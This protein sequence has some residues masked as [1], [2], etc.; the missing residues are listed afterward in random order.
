MRLSTR[1]KEAVRRRYS[2]CRLARVGTS[3][4]LIARAERDDP[5]G[6]P[7][8]WYVFEVEDVE[9]ADQTRNRDFIWIGQIATGCKTQRAAMDAA[10]AES[11]R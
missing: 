11:R 7:L 8:G 5:D 4:F 3:W 6:W 2:E 9:L 10:R 1:Q